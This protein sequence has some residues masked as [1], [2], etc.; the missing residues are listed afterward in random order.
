M[1]WLSDST[2]YSS[3]ESVV[4][5]MTGICW[6]GGVRSTRLYST[7]WA[8]IGALVLSCRKSYWARDDVDEADDAEE[9]DDADDADI[10]GGVI[11]QVDVEGVE[12]ATDSV[13]ECKGSG[14]VVLSGT[15]VSSAIGD[16]EETVK[17]PAK[18]LPLLSRE[19]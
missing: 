16:D 9:E 8:G 11:G 12:G 18:E 5:A 7:S 2:S 10:A 1:M 19:T 14:G 3:S 6:R 13:K 17:A 15:L 4:G